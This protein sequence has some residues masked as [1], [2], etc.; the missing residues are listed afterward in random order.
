MSCRRPGRLIPTRAKYSP[1]CS[2]RGAV[3]VNEPVVPAWNTRRLSRTRRPSESWKTLTLTGRSWARS[4]VKRS[5]LAVGVTRTRRKPTAAAQA[6][7]P[8][9][10]FRP[11]AA[12][13]VV[14]TCWVWAVETTPH[15]SVSGAGAL[16]S[17]TLTDWR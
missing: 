17:P 5:P 12:A 2:E 13:T 11:R 4:I 1:L 15:G 9:A 16:V 10:R 6:T 8:R 3:H 7:G 14:A